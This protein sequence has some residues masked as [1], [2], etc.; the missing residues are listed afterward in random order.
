MV[1]FPCWLPET[2]LSFELGRG[3]IPPK[4]IQKCRTMTIFFFL[5]ITAMLYKILYLSF[6]TFLF[7]GKHCGFFFRK[8]RFL[9][10]DPNIELSNKT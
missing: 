7:Q 2:P 4:E 3:K 6:K 10:I 1:F 5:R 9:E 8:W